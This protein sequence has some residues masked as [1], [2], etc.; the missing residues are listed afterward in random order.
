MAELLNVSSGKPESVPEDQVY[1]ALAK[2][3]HTPTGGARPLI[4]QDG[5]LQFSPASEVAENVGKYGYRVPTQDDLNAFAAQQQYGEG[6]GSSAK[7]FAEG[8]LRGGSFGLTD[9]LLPGLG[10]TTKEAMA[11]RKERNT[12]STVGELAGA[13]TSAALLPESLAG[14]VAKGSEAIGE[15]AANL[16][17]KGAA[18]KI[19]GKGVGSAV[20]GSAYG[21]GQSVSEHAL[22]DPDLNGEKVLANIGY[23]ALYGGGLGA[24]LKAGS[25]A[26]PAS[27]TKAQDTLGNFYEKWVGKSVD[28]PGPLEEGAVRGKRWEPGTGSKLW[29]KFSSKV[30]GEPEDEVI[31]KM[32]DARNPPGEI[33]T[34]AERSVV[35]TQQLKDLQQH[36]NNMDAALKAAPMARA[37]E[38]RALLEGVE[39]AKPLDEMRGARHALNS[40]IAEMKAEPAL[41]PS[42]FAREL[43]L[44][45]DQLENSTHE[46]LTPETFHTRE[47][48]AGNTVY[49]KEPTEG[50]TPLERHSTIDTE[51][52]LEGLG[53]ADIHKALNETKQLLGNIVPKGQVSD[54]DRRAVGLIKG[55]QGI[56]K[57]S[58]EKES[59]WGEAAARQQA[60][61]EAITDQI[62]NKANFESEF[63]KRYKKRGYGKEYKMDPTKVRMWFNMVNDPRG[64]LRTEILKNYLASSRTMVD[65]LGKTYENAPFGSGAF[66]KEDLAGLIEKNENSVLRAHNIVQKQPGGQGFWTDAFHAVKPFA[67]GAIGGPVAFMAALGAQG[68]T[69]A[70]NPGGAI[71]K[72]V[73][74]ESAASRVTS[75]INRTSRAI[76]ETGKEATKGLPGAGAFGEKLLSP[77]EKRKRFD[78]ISGEIL[79]RTADPEKAIYH[80]TLA[81]APGFHAAP[82]IMGSVQQ[83]AIRGTSFLRSKIPQP[84]V[85]PSAF[86]K[87]SQIPMAE[88]SRFDRYY[89]AVEK[90][91]S[92]FKGLS[93]GVVHP[94]G[95]EALKTVYP[96]LYGEMSEGI[97]SALASHKAKKSDKVVPY[98]QRLALCQ[99]LGAPIESSARPDNIAANQMTLAKLGA[100]EDQK[101]SAQL[102]F[103]V[104][105]RT[106]TPFQRASE[107]DNA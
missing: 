92:V 9:Y 47:T 40:T 79:Q 33:M 72:L 63:M 77:E 98:Q 62:A 85:G 102:N 73:R 59:V 68:F 75:S 23:G 5:Q 97:I 49:G 16:L 61:N 37:E 17:G 28:L 55:L 67:A 1:Q 12:S 43:E 89:A 86:S 25:L 27:I 91:M 42:R 82:N 36:Y 31:Q 71:E 93:E 96:R 38:T 6:A 8:A 30:S 34:P 52:P 18:A 87:G 65:Q 83:A 60:Y 32:V 10:I 58:L 13:V 57:E 66:N 106:T 101:E 15:G 3:T 2:G 107:D 76:F 45:R 24:F 53:A 54:A 48:E 11:E 80:L 70:S 44:V 39:L 105:G 46:P 100:E 94:E 21:L 99:F 56:L 103:N 64:Q 104:S 69:A 22:G 50:S 90:P 95:V 35:E 41:H 29:A 14:R 74:L 88:I 7:A 26:V 20:E 84:A 51:K 4:D 78:K 81:T 19:A